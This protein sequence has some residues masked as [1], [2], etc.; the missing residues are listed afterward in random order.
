M[1]GPSIDDTTAV[2]AT[3]VKRGTA[4]EVYGQYVV[5]TTTVTE[6]AAC[7]VPV[8]TIAKDASGNLLTCQ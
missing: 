3:L 2:A 4:G 1:D 6:N 5:P 8:G 7:T